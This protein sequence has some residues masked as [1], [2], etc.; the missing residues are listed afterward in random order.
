MHSEHT[1][2]VAVYQNYT[3][4]VTVGRAW[5]IVREI[6]HPRHPLVT[7]QTPYDW[8]CVLAPAQETKSLFGLDLDLDLD[9]ILGRQQTPYDWGCVLAPAQETESL[10]GLDLDLILDVTY[11]HSY[12]PVGRLEQYPHLATVSRTVAEVLYQ[13][14]LTAWVDHVT[15]ASI[16][17]LRCWW[18]DASGSEIIVLVDE[19]AVENGAARR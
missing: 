15:W 9:L 19:G 14:P 16:P 11:S 7:Q 2:V 3:T 5:A 18:T 13:A 6:R 17:I 10:F 12:R 1:D 8:G 4:T